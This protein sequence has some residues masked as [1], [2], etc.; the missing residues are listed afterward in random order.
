MAAGLLLYRRCTHGFKL[1]SPTA[2][3]ALATDTHAEL[4]WG[5]WHI[6]GIFGIVNNSLAC[7]YLIIV[8]FFSFWPPVTPVTADTMNYSV[9]VTGTVTVFSI[10]YYLVWAKKEYH[11]PTIEI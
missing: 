6:P 11:G 7:V 4:V 2:L 5:P 1:P 8:C 3:P 9:L 10:V